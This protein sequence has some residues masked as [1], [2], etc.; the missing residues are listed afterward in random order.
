ME[1]GEAERPIDN[2]PG[3]K[4]MGRDIKYWLVA[5]CAIISLS[6]S[7]NYLSAQ[8]IGGNQDGMAMVN[9]SSTISP[10]FQCLGG[11][12]DGFA[13]LTVAASISPG[14]CCFGGNG[15]GFNSIYSMASIADGIYITGGNEDGTAMTTA[16]ST[17][18]PSMHCFGGNNDGFALTDY[19]GNANGPAFYCYGG[20]ED[21]AG[22]VSG[23]GTISYPIY[24]FGG[25]NDG[26]AE[27]D[28]PSF[29]LGLG[30]WNGY[31]SSSWA[32]AGNWTN[33]FVP[34]SSFSIVIPGGCLNYPVITND[35]SVNDLTFGD[36]HCKRIDINTGAS[37]TTS[38][39]V[40]VNGVVNIE[41]QFNHLNPDS[42]SFTVDPG[43]ILSIKP[44]G[45]LIM[46][47]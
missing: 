7:P 29:F 26:H 10:S 46:Q 20:N 15:D 9:F 4:I 41:G 38:G 22:K 31:V 37:I 43:G 28:A 3:N 44:G 19:S 39:E 30:L 23:S 11:S 36:T 13:Q 6:F 12:E 33:S 40:K 25:N 27:V 2:H 8:F 35:F 21:G 18:S 14:I 47:P 42:L 32:S 45:S 24:C 16:A 1:E 34:D 17:I 5:F